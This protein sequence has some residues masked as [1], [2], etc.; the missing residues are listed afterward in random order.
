MN[1]SMNQKIKVLICDDSAILRRLTKE[2]LMA[3]KEMQVIGEAANG[4]DA[5]D[6]I[7]RTKP[8]VVLL[9]VEMPVMDG[10]DALRNI[11][12]RFGKLPVIMFSSITTGRQSEATI[13]AL[14][15][16]ANDFVAKPSSVGS[17]QTALQHVGKDLREKILAITKRSTLPSRLSAKPRGLPGGGFIKAKDV[18]IQIVG[19]G[20]S[21]GGPAAL[22]K[23]V[24]SL[25]ANL[26]VPILIT[27]HMPASFIKPLA[28]RLSNVG[29]YKVRPAV[30]NEPLKPGTILIAPG[31]FH[32]RLKR[33]D[34]QVLT[35]LENSPPVNSCRP[36]IDPMFDSIAECYGRHSLAVV[37][38]GMGR[39]GCDGAQTIKNRGGIVFSQDEKSCVVYGMPRE[40]ADAG[41]SDR[42][43]PIDQIGPEI[44]SFANTPAA[45]LAGSSALNN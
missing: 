9:D 35:F 4:R 12:K 18:T 45:A 29:S 38:T 32:L 2:A 44:S 6:F 23:V 33:Q 14:E 31:D 7:E 20:S 10:V 40:V 30:N 37:L 8:D 41:L 42:V 13:D 22:A 36:A 28:D 43:L 17:L 39:D 15:A 19:I 5:L 26:P 27:Q 11:R 21:T 16:G 1:N 34:K 3:Y 25:K 24:K